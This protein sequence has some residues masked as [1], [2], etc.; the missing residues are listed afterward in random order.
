MKSR[1]QKKERS[2]LGHSIPPFA[3]IYAGFWRSS[4]LPSEKGGDK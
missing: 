1:R 2:Y 3:D 4:R